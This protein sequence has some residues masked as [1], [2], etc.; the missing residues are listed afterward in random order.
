MSSMMGLKYRCAVLQTFR[1]RKAKSKTDQRKCND[2]AGRFLWKKGSAKI[3]YQKLL[4]NCGCDNLNMAGARKPDA[5]KEIHNLRLQSLNVIK[6]KNRWHQSN[7]PILMNVWRETSTK[8]LNSTS[9]EDERKLLSKKVMRIR[10]KN[11]IH[12][13]TA[14]IVA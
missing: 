3:K 11:S 14:P 13:N 4:E 8:S 5:L 1:G 9:Y 10:P 6:E 12:P 2:I 7:R